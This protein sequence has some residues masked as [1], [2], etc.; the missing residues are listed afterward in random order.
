[1]GCSKG[2]DHKRMTEAKMYEFWRLNVDFRKS[3]IPRTVLIVLPCKTQTNKTLSAY[4]LNKCIRLQHTC[5]CSIDTY[6]SGGGVD[7][8][9]YQMPCICMRDDE[10]KE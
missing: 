1:M 5:M 3:P 4:A 7:Y 10:Q 6:Y 2:N 8:Y 9:Y